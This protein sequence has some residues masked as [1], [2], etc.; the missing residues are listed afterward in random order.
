MKHNQHDPL[1][2]VLDYI[3]KYIHSIE[4]NIQNPLKNPNT[5]GAMK[6][7]ELAALQGTEREL[8][9]HFGNKTHKTHCI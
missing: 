3:V 7:S 1:Q 2:C 6:S 9:E 4:R 5:K 8:Q